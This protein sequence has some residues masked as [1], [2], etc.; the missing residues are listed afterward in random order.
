MMRFTAM[1]KTKPL[2]LA[3]CVASPAKPARTLGEF[4]RFAVNVVFGVVI[5]QSFFNSASTFVPLSKLSQVEGVIS[6]LELILVYFLILT[7]WIAYYKTTKKKAYTDS[8][9]GIARFGTD[10]LILYLYYH[11]VLLA[12]HENPIQGG[13][14]TYG[15]PVV[16]GAYVLWD[17]LKYLESRREDKAR[18]VSRISSILTTAVWLGI[19]VFASYIY[20]V[21]MNFEPPLS[22]R[23]T[24]IQVI[25]FTL[26]SIVVVFFYRYVKWNI[27]SEYLP[28]RRPRR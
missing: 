10:M 11:L 26:F 7:S 5:G 1:F 17:F 14:F 8:R 18:R 21:L 16:F 19:F 20:T 23:G 22:S 3:P 6:A 12:T 25:V 13:I 27:P 4:F 2:E 28:N 15:L 9:T 24:E